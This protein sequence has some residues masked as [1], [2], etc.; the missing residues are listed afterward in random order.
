MFSKWLKS[1]FKNKKT[2]SLAKKGK[3]DGD[4]T[5]S[6]EPPAETTSLPGPHKEQISYYA[7]NNARGDK[8]RQNHTTPGSRR[9]M[10]MTAEQELASFL[11]SYLYKPL[12]EEGRFSSIVRIDDVDMQLKG[13]DVEATTPTHVARID[14]K[15]QLYYINKDLPTFAFELQFLKGTSR[16]TGWLLNDELLTSHYLLIWPRATTDKVNDLKRDDF[17]E[18]DALMVSRRRI[19]D[20]LDRNGFSSDVLVHTANSLRQQGRIGRVNTNRSGIYYYVSDSRKYAE[21]P[22]NLV[23]GK[24]YLLQLADAHYKITRDG[25]ERLP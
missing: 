7:G 12:L 8:E 20:F 5:A 14:E 17:T 21:A 2:P 6:A 1:L 19:H 4:G 13:V 10:D 22:I 9:S 18:L 25:F 15:A 24:H 11:D 16:Y 3:T 23:I